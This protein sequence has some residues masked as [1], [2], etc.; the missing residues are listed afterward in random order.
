MPSIVRR[1]SEVEESRA[2]SVE[3]AA[4]ALTEA[5]APRTDHPPICQ[6]WVGVISSDLT[7][8]NHGPQLPKSCSGHPFALISIVNAAVSGEERADRAYA[9]ACTPYDRRRLG[10]VRV[11][12]RRK[13]I[14]SLKSR[15]FHGAGGPFESPP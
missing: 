13:V 7:A 12:H 9:N 11:L 1:A 14:S 4:A 8:D 5:R 10:E 15:R 6:W 3:K 2:N